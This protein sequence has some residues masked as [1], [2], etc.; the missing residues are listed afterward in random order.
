MTIKA[1]YKTQSC[2]M[3]KLQYTDEANSKKT[4]NINW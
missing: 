1:Y 4:Y 3:Q 2:F